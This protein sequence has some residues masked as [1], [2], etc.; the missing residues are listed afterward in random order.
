MLLRIVFFLLILGNLLLFAWGQG[1]LGG[2][3]E[4]REPQ[5]L[6][7]QMEADK[8]HIVPSVPAAAAKP[9]APA[10]VSCRLASGL[11]TVEAEKLRAALA[12]VSGLSVAV[13]PEAESS[14][15]WVMIPPLANKAAA[16]KKASELKAQGVTDYLI[17]KDGP[18]KF[19]IS[20]GWYKTENA[21]QEQLAKLGKKGVRSARIDAQRKSA[22][23]VQLEVRGPADAVAKGLSGLP[24]AVVSDCPAS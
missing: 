13:R 19:A 2:R 24:P 4:G 20:L 10:P 8:L 15:Y 17:V 3:D 11:G 1:Y 22:E 12:A 18:S 6:T 14:N 5:R 23:G 7:A 16:E 21:A 9:A